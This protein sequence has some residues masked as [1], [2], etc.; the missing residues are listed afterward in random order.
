MALGR[1]LTT[2]TDQMTARRRRRGRHTTPIASLHAAR[3]RALA[4]VTVPRDPVLRTWVRS[5]TTRPA[6]DLAD[7]ANHIAYADRRDP[8]AL[9]RLVSRYK[10]FAYSAARRRYRHDEPLDD[11]VQVSH[12]ALIQ[13]LRRF[14]PR[15]GIPFLAFAGPTVEGVLRR[16]FR[17]AGWA[18]RVPRQVHELAGPHRD[19]VAL[20]GQDLGRPPTLPEVA[21]FMGVPLHQ[22]QAVEQARR[23]RATTSLD[24]PVREGDNVRELGGPDRSLAGADDRVALRRALSQLGDDDVRLLAWYFFEELSQA[25]IAERLGVS[26]MQVSR[27]LTKVI[28]RLRPYLSPNL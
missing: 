15:R 11:L 27:L 10:G 23:A 18:L 6:V 21:D 7:W 9:D 16:H 8:E 26:Q 2:G 17:D 22:L 1:P 25:R 12:E 3:D 20:L 4:L 13:A 5:V 14:E 19:A 24:V 28:Q